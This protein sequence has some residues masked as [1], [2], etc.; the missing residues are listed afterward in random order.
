MVGQ[1]KAEQCLRLFSYFCNL[2]VDIVRISGRALA[3][4]NACTYTGLLTVGLF[5]LLGPYKPILTCSVV[6]RFFD[7]RGE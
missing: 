5:L 7:G 6:A 4:A 3:H 1:V 2:S